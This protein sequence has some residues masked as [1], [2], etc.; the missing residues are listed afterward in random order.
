MMMMNYIV[1]M[2][3]LGFGLHE[4]DDCGMLGLGLDGSYDCGDVTV[5]VG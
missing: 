1:G 3:T 2:L 5:R 4:N